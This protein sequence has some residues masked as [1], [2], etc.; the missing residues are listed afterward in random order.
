MISGLHH[1]C[2]V[3]IVRKTFKL[4]VFSFFLGDLYDYAGQRLE[5]NEVGRK[6][7]P[8]YVSHCS[9]CSSSSCF[10]G[11]RTIYVRYQIRFFSSRIDIIDLKLDFSVL[12][13][14]LLFCFLNVDL[15]FPCCFM[16]KQI[17]ACGINKV[18]ICS[19][20]IEHCLKGY[21]VSF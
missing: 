12:K 21:F 5:I 3:Y 20:T 6:F 11:F 1:K 18:P 8:F 4:N 19:S 14:L 10:D 7:I 2:V 16:W 15:L 17:S 9:T 13:S